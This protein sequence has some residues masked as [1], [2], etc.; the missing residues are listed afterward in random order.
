MNGIFVKPEKL[1]EALMNEGL[2]SYILQGL[3]DSLSE[4]KNQFVFDE[5]MESNQPE[6]EKLD[7]LSK[8][9]FISEGDY[10][11]LKRRISDEE[12]IPRKIVNYFKDGPITLHQA[13]YAFCE[14]K[15][16]LREYERQRVVGSF[17]DESGL[18]KLV[19]NRM[20]QGE[21]ELVFNN[22]VGYRRKNGTN[23]SCG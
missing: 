22:S 13:M 11:L 12:T 8:K 2:Y 15:E 1:E 14:N 18:L 20:N 6:N 5:I 10:D 7:N 9:G 16:V 19:K 4:Y 3:V 21:Y 17:N 23:I